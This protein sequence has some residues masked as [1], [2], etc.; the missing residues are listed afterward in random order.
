MFIFSK[1]QNGW[2]VH[3]DKM[4]RLEKRY[5]EPLKLN[6]SLTKIKF[7]CLFSPRK[8]SELRKTARLRRHFLG[9]A[10]DANLEVVLIQTVLIDKEPVP[11][12]CSGNLVHLYPRI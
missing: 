5:C 4:V 9:V 12:R 2:T 11:P 3:P 10:S 7:P 1:N 8:S 6:E